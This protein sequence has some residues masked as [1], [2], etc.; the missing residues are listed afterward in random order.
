[1]L[2][3]YGSEPV[4]M[5]ITVNSIVDTVIKQKDSIMGAT[6]TMTI[7]FYC[8]N[9]AGAMELAASLTFNDTDL[10]F[11]ALI[12]NMTAGIQ[13]SKIN[14]DKVTDNYCAW[15]KLHTTTLK[16]EINNAF[17]ALIPSFNKVLVNHYFDLPT[18]I[19]SLFILSNLSLGY[20]NDY[21][22]LGLTPT[23]VPPAA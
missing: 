20:F 12:K 4:D 7:E 18:Q 17:R 22:Y 10:Q 21:L 13:L 23:F 15:G 9:T 16:I 19:G 3:Y 2:N 6:I 14:I 11:T 5:F 1:M 8:N